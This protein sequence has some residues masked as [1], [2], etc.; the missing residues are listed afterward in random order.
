MTTPLLRT[1][2]EAAEAL[3]ISMRQLELYMRTGEITVRRLGK[4]CVR[5][6]QAELER[7]IARLGKP[8]EVGA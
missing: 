2:T 8:A 5:I 1:K 7:F 3:S 4:K 6:E